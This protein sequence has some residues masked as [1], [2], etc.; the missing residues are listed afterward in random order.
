MLSYVFWHNPAAGVNTADYEES[1][2]E[3]HR[4]L[5]A[6][7]PEGY[8]RSAAFAF[9]GAPWLPAAAG[10]LDW[11]AV[12]DFASLGVLNEAA[13]TGARKDPHDKVARLS[14]AGF[15]GLY[16]L[17]AGRADFRDT[18]FGTWLRK[19]DG[20]DYGVFR[21]QSAALVDPES[22]GLWQRQMSLGPG[23][24]FCL[25]GPASVAAPEVFSP[26][27]IELRQVWS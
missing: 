8:L 27:A 24:E 16:R 10:Y 20:L 14:G 15:G 3:F 12:A 13:V 22:M 23:L 11:Y 17:I 25:L 1:L 6:H 19:P 2:C 5:A 26:L 18:R 9:S 4:T 21:E 7:A